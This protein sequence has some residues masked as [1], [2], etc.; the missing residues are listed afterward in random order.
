[1]KQWSS[2]RP[3]TRSRYPRPA[4]T[5][6]RNYSAVVKAGRKPRGRRAVDL[7]IAATALAQEMPLFTRN[8]ADFASLEGLIDVHEV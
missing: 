5:Y 2:N 1:M 4:R 8:P 6:G 3:V 7:L